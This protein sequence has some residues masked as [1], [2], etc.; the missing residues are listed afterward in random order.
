[1]ECNY[2]LEAKQQCRLEPAAPRKGF[3][4]HK[5]SC[6]RSILV[7]LPSMSSKSKPLVSR[8]GDFGIFG[9]C[10]HSEISGTARIATGIDWFT[11]MTEKGISSTILVSNTAISYR[12]VCQFRR[13]GKLN[14]VNNRTGPHLQVPTILLAF[15]KSL[16]HSI[17]ANP[18]G[19]ILSDNRACTSLREFRTWRQVAD[20]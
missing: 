8:L 2:H 16:G 13:W 5:S 14:H 3:Y 12:D 19:T 6:D 11:P 18:G 20:S 1:M 9:L 4:L 7:S 15:L 10:E 17:P